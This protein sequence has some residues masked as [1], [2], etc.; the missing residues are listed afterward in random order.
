MKLISTVLFMMISVGLFAQGVTTASF[1]GSVAD[2]NGNALAGA[3]VVAVHLPSG[4]Q[5]GSSTRVDGRYNI[6][7]VRVGGPY[8]ISVSYVGYT[9]KSIEGVVV[10]I[11]ENRT[12]NFTLTETTYEGQAVDVVAE[13]NEILSGSRTG[14]NTTVTEE[15]IQKFPSIE[16][17]IQDFARLSPQIVGTNIGS[18]DNTGGSSSGGTNNRYNNVQID[19]AVTNDAF[20]LAASGTPGGQANAQPISLDAVQEFNVSVAPYDVRSGGFTGSLINAVTRSGT[21]TWEGSVYGFGRNQSITKSTLTVGDTETELSEFDELQTGF[22]IGGPI[23]KNKM[24]FFV[25]AEI[26]RRNDPR[27]GLSGLL[28]GTDLAEATAD[29]NA[30]INTARNTYGYEAGNFDEYTAGTNDNKAF[31]RLDWN[32]NNRNTLTLRHNFVDAELDRGINRNGFEAGLSSQNYVFNSVTNSTVL[33]WNSTLGSDKANMFRAS[34]STIRDARNLEGPKFPEITVDT[35]NID[36]VFGSERSSQAN[37][38]DQDILEITDDLVYFSGDHTFTVGTHNEFYRF[39]NLFVQHLFG[40]YEFDSFEDASGNEVS[41]AEAFA[42]NTP[43]RYRYSY[44]LDPNDPTPSADWK[45]YQIG[46]YAQDEWKMNSQ[47]VLTYGIRADVPIFPDTPSENERF[48][49][50]F[51]GRSTTD[52]PSGNVL[53]SPRVGFNYDATGDRETQLRGG[54]GIFSGRSP[55]VWLSNAYTN[56]GVEYGRVDAQTRFGD[57]VPSLVTDPNNQPRPG[58][59]PN[60]SP[61]SRSEINITS[62]DFKQPQVFRTNLGL[63]QKMAGNTILTLEGVFSQSIN[64]VVVRNINLLAPNGNAPD[65]RPLYDRN[66][67]ISN[68]FTS[69][70]ELDNSSKGWRY[71]LTAQLQKLN[72]GDFMPGLA[73]SISYT[74]GQSRDVN[75]GRSSTASSNWAFNE[76]LDPNNPGLGVSD[77]EIPHRILLNASYSFSFGTTFGLFYEG[78]SGRPFSLVYDN[79]ANG[80]GSFGSNDL[81]FVPLNED[82][83]SEVT[84]DGWAALDAFL[85]S[86]D[87]LA[88]VRGGIAPRNFLNEPW[89]NQLDLR[90]AQNFNF[91][92]QKFELTA[93][94]LNFLSLLS[95]DWGKQEFVNFQAYELFDFN[96]YDEVTGKPG[97]RFFAPSDRNGDGVQDFDDIFLTDN[98]LSRWRVQL[99]LRYSF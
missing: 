46:L 23:A 94:V 96:S 69:V 27:L 80:D 2:N 44:S 83:L 31:A 99:G 38:L 7:N 98:L 50:L 21:N 1:N 64:D 68:E 22:R 97:V 26:K 56:T 59:N 91:G 15:T 36:F 51:E 52:V 67:V 8:E 71:N 89:L 34:F 42:S 60:L 24:F 72:G 57:L 40:A 9:D 4:S 41:A 82:D 17:S 84:G 70:Y 6:P 63:D 81:A 77:F 5:Y 45:S 58:T 93:D 49:E 25:N 32:L 14:A 35:D 18:S 33:Q 85:N 78:R 3:N 19:G 86:N 65:G 30:I 88:A 62:E 39:D 47:F 61:I 16:R 10:A 43:S 73:G 79:D 75:S 90:L 76:T 28:T 92:G 13:Q 55:T 11:T 20:G 54:V 12:I 29:G 95:E 66:A 87:D 74:Y 48:G 37:S 53:W